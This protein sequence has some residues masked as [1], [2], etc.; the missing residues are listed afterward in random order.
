MIFRNNCNN[1]LDRNSFYYRDFLYFN[2]IKL[3]TGPRGATGPCGATG[4]CGATGP[5]GDNGEKGATGI[6]GL[7]GDKG[8]K[9]ETGATGL[10]GEKG[11]RGEQGIQGLQGLKG[12][13]GDKGEKG[14]TGTISNQNATIL[15]MA[16]QD[17]KNG[18]PL[19][20]TTILTNNGLT[21][22]GTSI[23][24]PNDGTYFVSY[25][26]NRA[27][28]GDGTDYIALAIDG[29]MDLNT[30]RPLNDTSTSSGHF[31]LNLKEG[32]QLSLIPVVLNAKKIVGNGGASSTLTVLRVS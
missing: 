1:I 24:V 28:Q 13:Q 31:I 27:D 21:I 26:V 23:T 25:Y 8:D 14:E 7:K 6:Q 17:I 32:N 16:S 22:G 15:S 4:A 10:K 12:D 11:D 5:K 19:L 2:N 18:E 20:M 29:T 3:I 30:A 9:G